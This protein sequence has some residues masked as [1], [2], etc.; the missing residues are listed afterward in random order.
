[1]T[2]VKK[3]II[4]TNTSI[5]MVPTLGIDPEGL[6]TNGFINAFIMDAHK[7]IQYEDSVYLVFKPKNID[8]FRDFLDNEYTRGSSIVDDYDYE[9]GFVVLVYTLDREYSRDFNLIKQ[10]KYSKTSS[11]FQELFPEKMR[12]TAKAKEE[13]SLQYRVFNKTNDLIEYWEE[14]LGIRF[15]N[16]MEVWEGWSDENE[17]LNLERIK[18]LV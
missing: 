8:K 7:D 10:G 4:W 18:E 16:R 5:F 12:K 14:K 13:L 15:D 11:V 9:K 3:T 1:M 17:T 2:E 6:K